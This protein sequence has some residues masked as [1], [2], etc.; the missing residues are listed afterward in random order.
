MEGN[1]FSA[2]M[3]ENANLNKVEEAKNDLERTTINDENYEEVV[4]TRKSYNAIIHAQ[5][6]NLRMDYKDANEN[7]KEMCQTENFKT[8]T[9]NGVA[10]LDTFKQLVSLLRIYRNI[11]S[12]ENCKMTYDEVYVKKLNDYIKSTNQ[13]KLLRDTWTAMNEER[14]VN[15]EHF[16]KTLEEKDKFVKDMISSRVSSFEE[17]IRNVVAN[18]QDN[19]E[20][21]QNRLYQE[22]ARDRREFLEGFSTLLGNFVDEDKIKEARKPIKQAIQNNTRFDTK[23]MKELN[24]NA[25]EKILETKNDIDIDRLDFTTNKKKKDLVTDEIEEMQYEEDNEDSDIDEQPT[26]K[27]MADIERDYKE[28]EVE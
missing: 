21:M 13:K 5:L 23:T 11:V 26:N 4:N 10:P 22:F 28:F 15:N 8:S 14:K 20:N 19:Y 12:W 2:D 9:D 18:M 16:R 24:E 1:I 17:S 27:T 7:Y 6:E 25:G 3:N